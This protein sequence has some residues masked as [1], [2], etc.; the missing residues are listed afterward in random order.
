[1]TTPGAVTAFKPQAAPAANIKPQQIGGVKFPGKINPSKI[2]S[3]SIVPI[4]L[5]AP[6]LPLHNPALGAMLG[7]LFGRIA[8]N[9]PGVSSMLSNPLV[10][11]AA[12]GA[13]IAQTLKKLE[14]ES[15]DG[16]NPFDTSLADPRQHG[17]N[18]Q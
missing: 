1:M 3:A 6:N 11:D 9:V 18:L 14:E 15:V 13:A 2:G 4:K 7:L 5:A 10:R 8:S 17:W 16:P 12:I